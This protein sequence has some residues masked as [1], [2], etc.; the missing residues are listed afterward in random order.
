MT[1]SRLAVSAAASSMPAVK[2][3]GAIN[4][5]RQFR[6][7]P[8][9]STADMPKTQSSAASLAVPTVSG[10]ASHASE[11]SA[12]TTGIRTK[13][14]PYSCSSATAAPFRR[15]TAVAAERIRWRMCVACR[16]A[17][18]R[19]PEPMTG[20]SP[21][22]T[23]VASLSGHALRSPSRTTACA[24]LSPIP[25]RPRLFS[26]SCSQ[27]CNLATRTLMLKKEAD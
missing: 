27:P 22:R 17:G 11:P 14:W 8:R 21:V 19:R 26:R 4:S 24:P 13:P 7:S 25:L 15:E 9:Q 1:V 5:G 10:S 2:R 6:R 16:P 23:C 18:A 20:K 12:S 3:A